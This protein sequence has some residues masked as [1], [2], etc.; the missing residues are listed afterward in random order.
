MAV[1]VFNGLRNSQIFT[2]CRAASPQFQALTAGLTAE[3]LDKGWEAN[4]NFDPTVVNEWFKITMKII[5]NKVNIATVKNPI[6]DY[7]VA[8]SYDTP[9]GNALQRIAL[10][11]LGPVDPKFHGLKNGDSIDM[12]KVRK[13][14]LKERFFEQNFDFQNYFTLQSFQVKQIL[15]SEFGMD[16]ITSGLMGQL[17]RSYTKQRYLNELECLNALIN[18]EDFP[19]QDTQV[20]TV[21]V[22]DASKY[23]NGELVGFIKEVNNVVKNMTLVPST[24]A[25]NAGKFDS[26]VN[27]DEMVLLV[28]PDIITDIEALNKLNAPGLGLPMDAKEVLNFG[29]LIPYTMSGDDKVPLYPVYDADGAQIGWNTSKEQTTATVDLGAELY[30]D[31]NENII[32][33]LIQKGAI[34]TT[35]QNGVEMV[36]TPYNARG[37]YMNYFFN[38][39]NAGIHGDYFYNLVIFTKKVGVAT[40]LDAPQEVKIVNGEESPVYTMAVTPTPTEEPTT[41]TP[42]P[43]E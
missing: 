29:G 5:L 9:W 41:P 11:D 7:G 15:Q 36:P 39:I 38:V 2:A 4:K 25:Y 21:D 24:K 19:L 43:T 28:R 10:T 6:E 27:K 35:M 26:A 34:F 23:S 30:E 18:S 31:P 42:T 8:E 37:A 1:T 14:E 20:V 22:A 40:P 32:A 3:N 17:E 16:Q 12:F 33:V 13:N